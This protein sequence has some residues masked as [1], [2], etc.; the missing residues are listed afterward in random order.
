MDFRINFPGYDELFEVGNLNKMDTS[1]QKNDTVYPYFITRFNTKKL[2]S[3]NIDAENVLSGRTEP[4]TKSGYSGFRPNTTQQ[5]ADSRP[6]LLDTPELFRSAQYLREKKTC[7]STK[8][9]ELSRLE[10]MTKGY[11]PHPS[12]TYQPN[13]FVG[14]NSREIR[15]NEYKN[16]NKYTNYNVLFK[17]NLSGN[18][19]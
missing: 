8:N 11:M 5:L 12:V 14:E 15:R 16:S 6:V 3:K 18:Y 13:T 7:N 4:L 10:G 1:P 19:N 2:D 9:I 17:N